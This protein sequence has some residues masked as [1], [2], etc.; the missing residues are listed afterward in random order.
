MKGSQD[1]PDLLIIFIGTKEFLIVSNYWGV[2][3]LGSRSFDY[4]QQKALY[5][6]ERKANSVF[7]SRICSVIRQY[8]KKRLNIQAVEI[9][10]KGGE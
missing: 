1:K 8:E 9:T 7:H 6:Y 10:N 4:D 3:A 2:V 5:T